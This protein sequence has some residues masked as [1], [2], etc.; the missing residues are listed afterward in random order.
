V[1]H[2]I[3]KHVTS[4]KIR[5]QNVHYAEAFT[6]QNIVYNVK[7]EYFSLSVETMSLSIST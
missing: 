3:A 5:R 2:T 6:Q 1:E 4:A 7:F